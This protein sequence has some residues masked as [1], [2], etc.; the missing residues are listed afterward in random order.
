[1]AALAFIPSP[2]EAKEPLRLGV[3]GFP[4]DYEKS[5]SAIVRDWS[6]HLEDTYGRELEIFLEPGCS[7]EEVRN[8]AD[9][10]VRKDVIAVTGFLCA[11]EIIKSFDKENLPVIDAPLSYDIWREAKGAKFALD[12][13]HPRLT[14]IIQGEN[15]HS[16]QST[17]FDVYKD[18]QQRSYADFDL[19]T[20]D[21]IPD[22]YEYDVVY[23]EGFSFM[24]ARNMEPLLWELH[25]A[26]TLLFLENS[27]RNVGAW[28]ALGCTEYSFLFSEVTPPIST[29]IQSDDMPLSTLAPYVR[30]I[31]L[32]LAVITNAA[33]EITGFDADEQRRRLKSRLL[34]SEPFKASEVLSDAISIYLRK[35]DGKTISYKEQY[36]CTFTDPYC[37]PFQNSEPAFQF[38]EL[39]KPGSELC[40]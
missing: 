32:A 11:K 8:A 6:R 16:L 35:Q 29:S 12:A 15:S 25:H 40:R 14:L 20:S 2:S 13:L 9:S 27:Y 18:A 36:G 23:L 5:I 34:D 33:E 24:D 22:L 10:L 38:G 21:D 19:T 26:D 28:Q 17:W 3:M 39:L 30:S 7:T 1:M 4:P 37:E 31:G